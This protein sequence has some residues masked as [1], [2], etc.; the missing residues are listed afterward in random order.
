MISRLRS[1][2]SNQFPFLSGKRLLL[3]VSG[4]IDSMVLVD[5]FK[6]L[7]FEIALAHC[8]FKLRGEESDDDQLFVENYAKEHKLQLFITQFDTQTFASD[9][10]LSIQVAARKLRYS[11]FYELLETEKFDFLLTAH[12]ADD[13][14]ETFLINLSRGTG[15]D[16]LTG[17]PQQNDK[18]IRPLLPFS[19]EEMEQYAIENK[20][21]WR[22]DSTNAS[23]KYLRNKIRQQL[24]PVLKQINPA[25]HN[26]FQNTLEYLQQSQ[27]MADDASRIVYRKVVTDE[28]GSKII[29]LPEL[30]QLP[31]YKAYLYQ[32]LKPFGFSAWN[33]IY[34]LVNAETGKFIFSGDYRLTKDRENLVLHELSEKVNSEAFTISAVP[35]EI[36]SPLNISFEI[37]KHISNPTNTTI[38][39]DAGKLQFPL[40]LRK[41]NE[42]DIFQPFGMNGQSKKVGKHLKDEKLSMKEKENTWL[43]VSGDQIAWVVGIRQ[44]ERF[45]VTTTTQTIMQIQ[46]F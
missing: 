32:W 3:A 12:H 35:A 2:L 34:D 19:R 5:L 23:D 44:D 30:M 7:P 25:F 46:L 33:D 14:I 29:H 37:V 6:E 20:I 1:H 39:A 9:Y 45:K 8:N 18:I 27:S 41:W 31:N 16:G 21:Q 38:F 17:I 15:L 22:E 10:K 11:W 43:L 26:S 36:K 4:G 40:I 24:V 13:V 28:E 42:A